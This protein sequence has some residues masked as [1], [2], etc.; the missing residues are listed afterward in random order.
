ML[1]LL[2]EIAKTKPS[3]ME[4]KREWEGSLMS[5]QRGMENMLF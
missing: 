1:I 2:M 4:Q 5:V 3:L